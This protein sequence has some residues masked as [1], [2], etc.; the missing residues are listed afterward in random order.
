MAK[1]LRAKL[2]PTDALRI[3]DV[4]RDAM[5]RLAGEMRS[6]KVGGAAVHLAES[7]ADSASHAVCFFSSTKFEDGTA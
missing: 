5:E 1:N 7:A 3:Y 2:A 6:D 4:N